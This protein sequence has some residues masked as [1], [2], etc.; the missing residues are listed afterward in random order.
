MMLVVS[1]FFAGI[2]GVEERWWLGIG[3]VVY[4]FAPVTRK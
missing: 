3:G 1:L 2:L 4:L